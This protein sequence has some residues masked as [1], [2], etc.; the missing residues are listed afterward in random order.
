MST[1]FS[2]YIVVEGPIGVGKTTLAKIVGIFFKADWNIINAV[3]SGVK[4][5]RENIEI[6]KIKK[7]HISL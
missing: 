1:E 5:I 7:P 4:D 2:G 3:S 6:G